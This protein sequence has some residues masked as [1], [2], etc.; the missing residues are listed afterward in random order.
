M[1]IPAEAGR[2]GVTIMSRIGKL[3]VPIT[4]GVQV[5]VNTHNEVQ[6]SSKNG[7]LKI[8]VQPV[9]S[10]AVKDGQVVLTR[11]NNEPQ[12]RAWHGLYRV[13]IRNAVVGVS[14]GWSKTLVMKGV[15]YKAQV[16]GDLLELSLGYSH[17]I[18]MTIP[19]GLSVKVAKTNITVSGADRALVG[20]FC[21]KV[22]KFRE[23]EPYL[24]KGIRYIDEV[25]R[26]KAGK[27]GGEKSK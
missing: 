16:K 18:K 20:E 8:P 22:R 9:I 3:P 21:A 5:Q 23:P 15:G 25:I 26:R 13:L 2:E 12:T 14:S 10:V 7:V 11:A 19:Q 17:P 6:V 1:V 4:E 27:S 24:G